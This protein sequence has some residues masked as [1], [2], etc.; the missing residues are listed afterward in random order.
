MNALPHILAS[1]DFSAPARSA[2]DR[3]AQLAR[4]AGAALSLM[5]VLPGGALTDLRQWWGGGSALEQHLQDDARTQLQQLAMDVQAAWS[6]PVQPVFAT[7][8]VPE[9]VQRAADAADA[10]LVVVGARG[11]GLLRR[12]VLG[13]TSERLLRRTQRPL[14]VVR[15][16]ATRRYQR[17]LVALDFSP[18]ST[19]AVALARRV[20]P[21]ARLVLFHAF[22]VPFEDKLHF[23]GVDLATIH[24]YR[25]RARVESTQRLHALASACQLLAGDWEPCVVEGEASQ[26]LL[27][28]EQDPARGCDLMVLGKHGQSVT[29]DLLLGSVS[30]HVLAEGQV[31]VLVSTV[32]DAHP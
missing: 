29:E 31:D 22:Q 7:G 13:S 19:Q 11:A 15:Q 25:Q 17:V 3:A 5:H 26:R 14:L 12:L 27:E 9:E 6:W 23:A 10:G 20:A 21:G 1:T 30:K 28:H 2:V 8:S 32:H 24:L 18:W 16:P 4:E